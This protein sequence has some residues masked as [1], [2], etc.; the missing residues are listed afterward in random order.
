M[1]MLVTARKRVRGSPVSG[2]P[3]D[4][5]RPKAHRN[6]YFA[7]TRLRKVRKRRTALGSPPAPSF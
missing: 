3:A 1:A 4:V 5:A 2:L 6:C 7:A